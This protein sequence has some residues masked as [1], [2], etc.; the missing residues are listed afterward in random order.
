[1]KS[2]PL[3]ITAVGLELLFLLLSQ[4]DVR[5]DTPG[6]IRLM[7]LA[8]LFYLVCVLYVSRSKAPIS[9]VSVLGAALLFRLTIAPVMPMLSGDVYRYRWEGLVQASGLN[10]Y[11]VSPDET[12][13]FRDVTYPR[14]PVPSVRSGYGPLASL[15]EWGAYETAKRLTADPVRQAFWMKLPSVLFELLLLLAL[16]RVL[17]AGQLI[18][19]AWCPL[20]VIEF[21][22][23]G[24]NDS[25]AVFGMMAAL[26]LSRRQSWPAAHA[27]L[28]LA[29]AVKWWPAILW[30]L[31]LAKTPR[32]P[33]RLWIAPVVATLTTLPYWTHEWPQLLANARY[34]SG[35]VGGWRNNDSLYGLLLAAT[36]DQ[37]LAKY[38]AFAL[39]GVTVI[40]MIARN[41]RLE[42]AWL[43]AL[44]AALLL[45]ANC[46]PWY[47]TWLVPLAAFASWPP[48][49]IWQLLMPLSYIVLIEWHARGV[50]V[51][52][53]P[54][55]W[56]IYG[57]VFTAM[58]AYR[59]WSKKKKAAAPENDGL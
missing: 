43:G 6:A 24:H 49:L 56:W 35:Y 50:W 59:W 53:R 45:S 36:G 32:W 57:P 39:L 1:M 20:P 22:W 44:V 52:S 34:M 33:R 12:A 41:W 2:L 3:A 10:P 7:I 9:R 25:L 5:L 31:L 17:P 28:G 38:T 47:L 48:L 46:H 15:V 21:W 16:S 27:A 26:L 11:L 55:R 51:G 19:Y 54:D 18:I 23:N 29:I 40:W 42:Q 37:Y 14:I 30:P 4:V 58:L 13:Q 8:S